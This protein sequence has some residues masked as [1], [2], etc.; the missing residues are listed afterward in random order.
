MSIKRG[1]LKRGRV[2]I[3]DCFPEDIA[4]NKI[5]DEKLPK[6]NQSVTKFTESTLTF[7]SLLDTSPTVDSSAYELLCNQL[8]SNFK[9]DGYILIRSAI[10]RNIIEDARSTLKRNLDSLL[11]DNEVKAKPVGCTID[12]H[13]GTIIRGIIAS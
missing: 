12:M 3:S 7:K 11:P 10:C 1:N 9:E 2:E 5:I 6:M 13:H 4:G 8:Y